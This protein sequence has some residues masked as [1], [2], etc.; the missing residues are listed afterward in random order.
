MNKTARAARESALAR[1]RNELRI[2]AAVG[3]LIGYLTCLTFGRI[4]QRP[5]PLPEPNKDIVVARTLRGTYVAFMDENGTFRS[6][7]DGTPIG[8]VIQ[9]SK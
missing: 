6:I 3:L 7:A 4:I 8:Q 5:M 2:W 9:W 1:H